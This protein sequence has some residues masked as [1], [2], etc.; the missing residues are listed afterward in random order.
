MIISLHFERGSIPRECEK[1][2]KIMVK[3]VEV[4]PYI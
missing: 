4:L 1:E 2:I 3:E